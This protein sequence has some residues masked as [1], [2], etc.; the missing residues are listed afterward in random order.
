MDIIPTSLR[1]LFGYRLAFRCTTEISSDIILGHGWAKAGY[2]ASKIAPEDLG[3]GWLRAE[4]GV[5]VRIKSA[6]LTDEQI[7]DLVD[8]AAW[9]RTGHTAARPRGVPGRSCGR[10][11]GRIGG[12]VMTAPASE[13]GVKDALTPH[14]PPRHSR[15]SG[16]PGGPV[17]ENDAYSAF[18]RRAIR[19]AGRRVAGGDVE[20]L[21]DLLSLAGELDR[22][23][24]A[25]V[26]GLRDV[27][28]LLGRDRV[29]ARE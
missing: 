27:G 2:D 22:A 5:P 1:D 19:A 21:A 18:L 16:R 20:G 14:L 10:F 7:Y 17:V 25:A 3:V 23:T 4:G 11:G 15:R 8:Y 26:R 24:D 12:R 6:L 29:P 28:L 9:L 13:N